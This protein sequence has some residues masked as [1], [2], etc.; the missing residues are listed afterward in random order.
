M[1]TTRFCKAEARVTRREGKREGRP[2]PPSESYSLGRGAT[3]G[4]KLLVPS[5]KSPKANLVPAGVYSWR[6]WRCCRCRPERV[7]WIWSVFGELA[8]QT[9]AASTPNACT[10]VKACLHPQQPSSLQ[11]RV[12]CVSLTAWRHPCSITFCLDWDKGGQQGMHGLM[13]AA[14]L[15]RCRSWRSAL[16]QPQLRAQAA[17]A[18][19]SVLS[20]SVLAP[21]AL[22]RTCPSLVPQ[23]AGCRPCSG[24]EPAGM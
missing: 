23:T 14:A 16:G 10:L 6:S 18:P 11:H 17:A 8:F 22:A 4:S 2:A 1:T 3:D 9:G 24:A 12:L 13:S 15:L 5:I 20:A 21:A 7:Q 19:S